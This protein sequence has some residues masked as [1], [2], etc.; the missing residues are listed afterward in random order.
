[1]ISAPILILVGYFLNFTLGFA[2][3]ATAE[4]W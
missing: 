2:L 1:M 4:L 3:L